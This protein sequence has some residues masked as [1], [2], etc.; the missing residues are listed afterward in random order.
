MIYNLDKHRRGKKIP[1]DLLNTAQSKLDELTLLLEPCLV[2]L[3]ESERKLIDKIGTDSIKFLKLSYEISLGNPEL[4][5]TF[6]KASSFGENINSTYELS[7]LFDKIEDLRYGISDTKTLIGNF[8]MEKALAFYNTIKIA[9]RR[10]IPGAELIY[11]ELKAA[12]P[13][14]RKYTPLE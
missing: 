12:F 11:K 5:P 13:P 3:E 10:D 4:F 9:A 6:I 1:Q 8:A 7:R 2:S 14:R